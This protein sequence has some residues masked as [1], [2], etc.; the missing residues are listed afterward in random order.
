MEVVTPDTVVTTTAP[1]AATTGTTVA[2]PVI[3]ET[4]VCWVYLPFYYACLCMVY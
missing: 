3:M 1:V 4:K 2:P